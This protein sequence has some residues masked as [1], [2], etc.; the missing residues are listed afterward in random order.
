MLPW[1]S[2]DIIFG[3]IFEKRAWLGSRDPVNVWALN[4]NISK[5]V[6]GA[7]FE[8]GKYAPGVSPI[9]TPEKI[10]SKRGRGQDLVTP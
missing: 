10:Y 6:E 1:E 8:F 3:K 5:T 9:M 2:A 7:N 4:V